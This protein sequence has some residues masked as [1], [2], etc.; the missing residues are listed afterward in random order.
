[1]LVWNF[2]IFL[3]MFVLIDRTS[4]IAV[5]IFKEEAEIMVFL[6]ERDVRLA[7]Q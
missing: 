5:P 3:K 4:S 1:M 2:Y 7:R 6:L